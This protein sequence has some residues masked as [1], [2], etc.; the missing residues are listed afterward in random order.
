MWCEWYLIHTTANIRKRIL[1]IVT[2]YN[3]DNETETTQIVFVV[4]PQKN[5]VFMR[6]L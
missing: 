3:G 2:K 6:T 1:N 4:P 5:A